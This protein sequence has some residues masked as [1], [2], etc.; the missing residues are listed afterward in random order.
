MSDEYFFL[1]FI[2][3]MQTVKKK[4]NKFA[5]LS[6]KRLF[7]STAQIHMNSHI[8]CLIITNACDTM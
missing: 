6:L 3:G 5:T 1:C 4:K 7:V 2:Y 8:N